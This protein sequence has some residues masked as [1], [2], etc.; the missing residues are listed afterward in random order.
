MTVSNQYLSLT[1]SHNLII[2]ELE[3]IQ[4]MLTG[5]LVSEIGRLKHLSKLD[6]S[7]NMLSGKLP[8]EILRMGSLNQ[9]YLNNN[10]LSGEISPVVR[11]FG[12]KSNHTLK[13]LRFDSNEFS[14][15]IPSDIGQIRHLRK[16]IV[17]M[18]LI[19]FRF[20]NVKKFTF[21]FNIILNKLPFLFNHV[22]NLNLTANYFFGTVPDDICESTGSGLWN[23]KFLQVDCKMVVCNCC[24]PTCFDTRIIEKIQSVSDVEDVI[25]WKSPRTEQNMAMSWYTFIDI[26]GYNDLESFSFERY[27][28]A[29]LYFATNGKNWSQSTTFL[30]GRNE[31]TWE[32]VICD[33]N[34]SVRQIILRK[35]S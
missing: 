11:Y 29:T 18:Y 2:V 21:T 6:V 8:S 33:K 15:T 7:N 20:E 24:Q 27:A 35:L 13:I 5:P 25:L 1:F 28:L 17:T 22:G 4:N 23:L 14:G 9:L 30:S 26:L 31:C 10:M 32:G 12:E 34:G 19:T 3:L 16:F